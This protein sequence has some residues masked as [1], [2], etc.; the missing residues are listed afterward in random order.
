M[1]P[2]PCEASQ[3]PG[4]TCPSSP[5]SPEGLLSGDRSLH[6]WS[7]PWLSSRPAQLPLALLTESV[8]NWTPKRAELASG[9]QIPELQSSGQRAGLYLTPT[10]EVAAGL[11]YRAGNGP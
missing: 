10:P 8:P 4:V 11:P 2:G 6:Q 1:E 5:Q 3:G 7:L 9:F